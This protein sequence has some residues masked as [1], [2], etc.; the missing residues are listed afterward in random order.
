M[1][2]TG[3]YAHTKKYQKAGLELLAVS[4]T[5]PAFYCWDKWSL[6]APRKELF[7]KWKLGEIDNDEYLR[8]YREYLDSVLKK[9][10][11]VISD[12]IECLKKH[13]VVLLC[14]EK[15][16]DFCHR[17]TLAQWLMDNFDVG[18]IKE[19]EIK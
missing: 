5:T 7:S 16:G 9:I 18:E 14:Y 17:H 1:F 4:G 3:Y 10:P 11:N 19:Y 12:Y 13:D 2:Y 6:V 15:S 8:R